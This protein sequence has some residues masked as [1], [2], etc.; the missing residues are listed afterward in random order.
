MPTPEATADELILEG[1]VV[2]QDGAGRPNVAPMGPR[3]DRDITR[4]SLRPFQTSQT[5]QN[6]K[7]LGRGVFHVIDDVGL[8]AQAAI[9]Q[10]EPL[11]ALAPIPGF[12]CPRLASCCRWFSFSV[13]ALDDSAER[14]T[15]DCRVIGRGDVRPF[16]GFNRAKH[17]VLEAAIHATRIGIV[18]AETIRSDLARLAVIVQKTAGQQERQA[19]DLL[20]EYIERQLPPSFSP[21]GRE[22]G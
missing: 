21:S 3:V 15:I 18:P 6:L 13:A 9:G 10:L 8:L 19:F 2:T 4:L 14:T 12:A 16:F 1:I 7:A 5:Y 20:S 22:P 17:A 11:P